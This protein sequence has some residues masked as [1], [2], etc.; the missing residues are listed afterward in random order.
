MSKD[1]FNMATAGMSKSQQAN[2][3][4]FMLSLTRG[5]ADSHEIGRKESTYGK[6]SNEG[7][8]TYHSRVAGDFETVNTEEFLA[9]SGIT[10]DELQEKLRSGRIFEIPKILHQKRH[11]N[12]YPDFFV[13]PHF[14]TA[15]VEAVSQALNG[16]GDGKFWF[17]LK[18][19]HSCGYKTPL[20][21]LARGELEKV[22]AEARSYRNFPWAQFREDV[23]IR[24]YEDS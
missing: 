9:R 14:D 12:Y 7:V 3:I 20:A 21:A 23:A 6:S 17:F 5:V 16:V 15:S 10:R 13:D 2:L 22:I 1:A 11:E 8:I 4:K 18:R 19:L 24:T